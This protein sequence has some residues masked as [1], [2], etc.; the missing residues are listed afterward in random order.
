LSGS[1]FPFWNSW[2]TA[3]NLSFFWPAKN[4]LKTGWQLAVSD[5][6]LSCP[7]EKKRTGKMLIVGSGLMSSTA[8]FQHPE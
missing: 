7:K 2:P 5:N 3:T 6:F 1:K 8:V 4:Y